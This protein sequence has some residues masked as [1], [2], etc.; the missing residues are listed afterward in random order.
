MPEM[1]TVNRMSLASD[2]NQRAPE[3]DVVVIGS[4]YGGAITAARISKATWPV[5]KPTICILERG[6]EWLPGQFPD[7]LITGVRELRTESNPLGLY[8]FRFDSDVAVLMGSGLG[9]TSLINANVIFQ[10]DRE[11]FD[12][13]QW[14]Q[15]I[16]DDRDS[17][18]LR[19]YFDRVRATLSAVPHPQGTALSKV[20]ALR[21]GGDAQHAQF[22]LPDIA[23]NFTFDGPNSWGV[24]QQ[25]CINC[26]DCVTGCNVGAKNTLDTN[27]LALAKSSG[28]EL[29]TQVEVR[30]IEQSPGGGYLVRY[31]RREIE[32]PVSDGTLKANRVVVLAAGALGSTE[33]LLRSKE[34]GL[35][36]PDTVGKRFSGNGDF[37]GL[38]Y[39]S[40]SRTDVL[41]WGAYPD[42]NRA[43]RIQPSPD[44]RL[45]PGP[46]IVGS[47]KYNNNRPLGERVTVEELSFPLMYVDAAR[48]A[49]AL[50]VGRDTDPGNPGDD[51]REFGRRLR[52]QGA[53]NPELEEGALNH[54]LFYLVMGH[55]DAGGRIELHPQ[56]NEALTRWPGIG[57]QGLFER[58]NNL[59]L[60]HAGALGA[61]FVENPLA[62]FTPV[63]TLITAH[64]LGGCPMGETHETAV[65]NEQGQVFDEQGQLHDGL[66]VAD[67]SIIPTAI[68]VNPLLTISAMAERIAEKL[69]MRLGGRA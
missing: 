66:Y 8:D 49:Y 24:I 36:L 2:W 27:Y 64:P 18:Q 5:I 39:N 47:I 46:T 60:G 28:T 19:Q 4:G 56:S 54:T 61:T 6:K 3:Y 16:R 21:G 20:R 44:N 38:A 7:S 17:G 52:D 40:D 9:G 53:F 68:G 23:V 48:A 30:W 69:I 13:P 26:G 57:N 41:G 58:E 25:K 10:P 11:V 51:L 33:I 67:G 14:P 29:F 65:V 32:G 62:G 50:V 59:I 35:S 31:L 45:H 12:N 43:K 15:A 1:Y 37:F 42:S 55:D 34:A 22:G 63:C